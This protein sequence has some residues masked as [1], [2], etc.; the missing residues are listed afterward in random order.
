MRTD[1]KNFESLRRLLALKRFEKPPPG[2]FQGFSAQVIS[3]IKA[4]EL[5]EPDSTFASFL[6]GFRWLERLR[7]L[8]E[9]KPAFAGAFGASV[10]ALLVSVVIYSETG[11][12]A[13]FAPVIAGET[14]SAM[15]NPPPLAMND[16]LDRTDLTSSTNAVTPIASSLFDQIM[17]QAQPASFVVPGGH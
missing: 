5:G 15:E 12:S 3:R 8:L 9:A 14:L 13:P 6:G 17:P 4:G 11:E 10:C 2:Y 16:S 7:S 1:S